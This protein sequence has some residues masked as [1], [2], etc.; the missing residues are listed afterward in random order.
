MLLNKLSVILCLAFQDQTEDY[1]V[2][3]SYAAG[4]KAQWFGV[5]QKQIS[6][7]AEQENVV[8]IDL[9]E[10]KTERRWRKRTL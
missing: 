3:I 10:P 2:E 5:N 9:Y 6:D 1:D 4:W 7:I 8:S